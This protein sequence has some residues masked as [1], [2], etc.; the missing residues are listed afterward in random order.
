MA[1]LF[2]WYELAEAILLRFL[3]TDQLQRKAQKLAG[4][5]EEPLRMICSHNM[6]PGALPWSPG[7]YHDCSFPLELTDAFLTPA[8]N[9]FPQ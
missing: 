6:A 2:H 5:E 4:C 1:A 7:L 8:A 9:I 3:S